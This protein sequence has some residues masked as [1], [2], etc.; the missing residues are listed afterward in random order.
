MKRISLFVFSLLS[1]ITLG[2]AQAPVFPITFEPGTVTYSF[3]NF[4]GG[5]ATTMNNPLPAGINTS[6]R[7]ARLIKNTGQTYGG[8]YMSLGS[9]I[10]FSKR[11]TFTLKVLSPRV[12]ARLL[13]KAENEAN[14]LIF[15]E[16][17]EETTVANAW[18]ELH[19]DF[20]GI[21][22]S[23]SYQRLVFIFDNGVAGDGSASYTFYIDDIKLLRQ[24]DLP[25][26]FEG[27]SVD[28]VLQD[29]GKNISTL[30]P[31]PTG[32]SN[33]VAK[34]VK[35]DSAELWSGTTIG[36]AL[37][38]ASRMN[39]TAT[40]AII[41][42]RVYSPHAGIPVRLQ[43]ENRNNPATA[44]FVERTVNTANSWQDL[45]FSFINAAGY[46][47]NTV[48]DKLSIA[49]NYGTTGA[50]A[51][52]RIYY[53]DDVVFLNQVDL[54]VSFDADTV[55]YDFVDFGNCLSFL[56]G[57]PAGG[58]NRVARTNKLINAEVW[59]GTT[60]GT[61]NGLATP[62]PFTSTAATIRV[63][64]YSPQ[65]GIPVR[66]QVEDR[67][68]PATAI[69]VQRNT[70]VANA[71]HELTFDFSNAAGFNL[72]TDYNK[73]SI[74]FDYGTGGA[75]A[76][77]QSYY[78]DDVAFLSQLG[79]PITFEDQLINYRLEDF[80]NN[81]SA[82]VAD[83]V[84][85]T[86]RVGRT[87]KPANAEVWAG[88]TVGGN[89][90]LRQAIPFATDEATMRLRVYAPDA[91]TPVRLQVE[92][93][94]DPTKTMIIDRNTQVAN[95][96]HE[97]TFD[98]RNATGFNP[99]NTYDKLLI[100]F[101]YGVGGATAGA[102]TYYWDDVNFLRRMTLPVDFESDSIDYTF[103]DF[104]NNQSVRVADPAGTSNIVARTL[105]PGNAEVWAGTTL[106]N[107]LGLK[108]PIPFTATDA[109]LRVRVY[110]PTAGTTVRMQVENNANA[111]QTMELNRTANI[112][113]TWIDLN[114]DF[115]TAAGFN[116]ANTYD[117]IT[118]YF[119]YGIAGAT[120]GPK[121]YYWD[122]VQFIG[123]LYPIAL[124][125][126]FEAD[127]VDYTLVDFGKNISA[128]F[129]DPSGS[130]N[131]VA[132]TVKPADAEV[133]AGTVMG[134][135]NGFAT[136]MPF[137][138][139]EATIRVRIWS[140]DAG[141]PI[142]LEAGD[143]DD[144]T[145][146]I[147]LTRNTKVA[148]AWD[149]LN[150]D[151]TTATGFSA[152]NTYDKLT[153][154]FNYGVDGATAGAK[155]YYWDDVAFV[156]SLAQI[157][158]PVTFEQEN[159]DYYLADFG[160]N[161]SIR[162]TDPVV[163]TNLVGKTVKPVN[164][165]DWAGTI[166]GTEAG[167]ASPIPFLNTDTRVQV[168]TYS[169][170]AGILVRLTAENHLDPSI[171]VSTEATTTV[172]NTWEDLVFEFAQPAAGSAP[173]NFSQTYDRLSIYFNYGVSG[174]GGARTYY[175]DDVTFIGGTSVVPLAQIDLPV[176]F[177]A[178]TVDY[179][180]ADFG[181]QVSLRVDDPV[182]AS[183]KV[184]RSQRLATAD[185]FAGTIVGTN[186]GFFTP[187]PFTAQQT[188]MQVRVYAP[189]AGI[190]V[191]LRA[192]DR[193]NTAVSVE[194]EDTT[195]VANAWETLVFDFSKPMPGTLTLNPA[196]TYERLLIF[197]NYGQEG[198][199]AGEQT[200]YWDDVKFGVDNTTA[201]VD[202]EHLGLRYYPNPVTHSLTLT[203]GQRIDEVQVYDLLGHVLDSH[204]VASLPYTLDLAT[205][206][207]GIYLVK[208]RAAGQVAAFRIIKQ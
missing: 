181:G 165:A 26:T 192:T 133:W 46:D 157:D 127:S 70:V 160:G 154:Y 185:A 159:V 9:A 93:K 33:T 60:L 125:L 118:L 101:N 58:S 189:A 182:S 200:F 104:G 39:F 206:S 17:E 155:T 37:G 41:R 40:S 35:P 82:V 170:Q 149:E 61:N 13:L 56:S 90:G 80:G 7:V 100:Y 34:T 105:K 130:E 71:W 179:T 150:F 78:W 23:Q 51:G 24:V 57:D 108:Q 161:L 84:A 14:N 175:W 83:P 112:A 86:N 106:G 30:A 171:A 116:P 64:V 96:W 29:Y 167:F 186:V 85:P 143:H 152:A 132:R 79:L 74:Y 50:V 103:T 194:T 198:A 176:S 196:A 166:I 54:P 27:D 102:K 184:A 72:G 204:K 187:I 25:L 114:F 174:A 126:T 109:T 139:T 15:Y 73:L 156:G 19:F 201:I 183:N 124:P 95:A 141:I 12:G 76:G 21:N 99:A 138:A 66:I 4:D 2:Y 28:F 164:A 197:F 48:Y 202:L 68:N 172:A 142:R 113:N 1:L 188:R 59:A 52:T 8:S 146:T 75:T 89:T 193:T 16:Q 67:N 62:I 147:F 162:D 110:V 135:D 195:T 208:V 140:P 120:A 158:L 168:R 122:D 178:D 134:T 173:L 32:G 153:I 163:S 180:L 107:D 121:T 148:N 65:A 128:L 63:R 20:S 11:I 43:A 115:S 77:A 92:D 199:V 87:Q 36:G 69:F 3:T 5:Q 169:P 117:K 129:D 97:L 22:T 49:F 123:R 151:F 55:H 131:R 88:T 119:D 191:R 10:D 98:F 94:N 47:P 205:L 38:F 207:P 31:D 6:S 177:D 42:M 144:P 91:G 136:P 18:E 45:T 111:G 203:A 53:W 137:T 81:V 190:P 145:K 44:I